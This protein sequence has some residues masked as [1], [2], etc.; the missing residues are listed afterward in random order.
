MPEGRRIEQ[1]VAVNLPPKL[2]LAGGQNS[3][4]GWREGMKSERNRG[5]RKVTDVGVVQG[6]RRTRTQENYSCLEKFI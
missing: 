2:T 6:I 4:Q 3:K 5:L 1:L